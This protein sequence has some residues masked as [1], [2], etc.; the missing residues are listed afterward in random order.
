MIETLVGIFAIDEK[1]RIGAKQT[2]PNDPKTIAKIL[3]RLREGDSSVVSDLVDEIESMGDVEVFS[4]NQFL[5][6]SLKD[7]FNIEYL[8]LHGVTQNLKEQLSEL[9]VE[10][11]FI[12]EKSDYGVFSHSVLNELT[13]LDVHEKLSYR[14]ALLIP[15]VQLLGELDTVLNSL[16]SRLREWY[17]VHFPEMGR[18]VREHED[19]ARI[20][21]RLGF[22]ENIKAQSLMEMSLKKKDAIRIEE[23]AES[24]MGASYDEVDMNI[25]SSYAQ[26]TLD[27]YKFREDLVNYISMVTEEVAPNLAFV[28]GPVLGAKLIEKAGSLKRL[29]MIPSSTIQV[30][31]AEKALFRAL[32]SNARPPKHGLLYQHPY[33]NSAARDKRGNRARSLAAKIAIAARADVFSGNFIAEGLVSQLEDFL[34]A[35]VK[36]AKSI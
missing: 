13:R 28:A 3:L 6:D 31:G 32:K 20:I 10:S 21:S 22:R 14:E 34:D 24:S 1:N 33:V 36:S 8:E 18:R 35:R 19:Y 26:R 25:V 11:G 30:L 23:A 17:G 27:M 12:S 29:G 15:A 7:K 16:S 5:V 2:W 9:A 4:S